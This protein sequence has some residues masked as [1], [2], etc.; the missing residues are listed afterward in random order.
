[1][2]SVKCESRAKTQMTTHFDPPIPTR[3][4]LISRL[5]DWDDRESWKDFFDAY[6]KLIYGVAIKSGLTHPEAQAWFRKL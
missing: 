1:M 3:W 4:S 5:K 2:L 6:W